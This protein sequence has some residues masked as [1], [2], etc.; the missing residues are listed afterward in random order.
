MKRSAL[1]SLLV[2]IFSLSGCARAAE[3]PTAPGT[4]AATSAPAG[5]SGTQGANA[6]GEDTF[7]NPVLRY[8][9]PDPFLLKEGDTWYAYATNGASRNVQ[10]ATSTDLVTWKVQSDAMP[11]LASWV[12]F[13]SADV[14][15]P[16]VMKIGERYNLYYTARDKASG[17]QCVG[18]A[19][20]D[21]PEG[22]FRDERDSPLVC[23]SDEGGTIDASPFRDGDRLYLYF[24]NDGNCCGYP[25]YIY[26]QEM[27][28][29]GLS[30]VGEPVRLLRNDKPWEG[31]VIEA[32]TMV[33]KEEQYYLFFSANNFGGY[34]YAVGYATCETATGPCEDAPENPILS[35]RMD[36]QPLVVGPGHQTIIEVDGQDWLVY[37]A[38]EV[39]SSGTR[40]NNRFMWMDRL[41]WVDGKPEVLGPTTDPQPRP[42]GDS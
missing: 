25:T 13:S 28:P 38:W 21:R 33:K 39:L 41:E 12:Q 4:A 31:H 3:T 32:P 27:A 18:V 22:K 35:S 1:L 37:H 2:I 9:F 15:A 29:D 19:V 17:K 42:L 5:T 20:S 34:E 30:L 16:E 11:A 26:V 40:G 7:T 10:M 6:S 14:W 8:N 36:E 23:Q 24:K